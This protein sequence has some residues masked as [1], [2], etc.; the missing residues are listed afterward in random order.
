[1]PDIRP[2][3]EGCAQELSNIKDSLSDYT[4]ENRFKLL[5]LLVSRVIIPTD[6][7]D[8]IVRLQLKVISYVINDKSFPDISAQPF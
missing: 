6:D 8:T 1:M 7:L 4:F 5:Q 3:V 2:F